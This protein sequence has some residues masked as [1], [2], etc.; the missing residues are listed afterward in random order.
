VHAFGEKWAESV[1]NVVGWFA[2]LQVLAHAK[3]TNHHSKY[4]TIDNHGP[5]ANEWKEQQE[6]ALKR[7]H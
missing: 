1:K 7:Q 5:P 2:I 4:K 6:G 3:A